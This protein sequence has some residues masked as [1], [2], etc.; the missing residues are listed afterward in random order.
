MGKMW[1]GGEKCKSSYINRAIVYQI[2]MATL[3]LYLLHW[4]RDISM[5]V[6]S[7]TWY[8]LKKSLT[9]YAHFIYIIP[10][11]QNNSEGRS[12]FYR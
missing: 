11:P 2:K 1:H 9:K 12:P 7:F 4:R 3:P 8:A 10:N 5:A 6:M